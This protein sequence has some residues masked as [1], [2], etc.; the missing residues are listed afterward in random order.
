LGISGLLMYLPLTVWV[1]LRLMGFLH[2]P[3]E[4]AVTERSTRA[5]GNKTGDF[6]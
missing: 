4:S 6:V 3:Y 2:S 1:V 5:G